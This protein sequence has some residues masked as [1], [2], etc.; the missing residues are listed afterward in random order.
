MP[1]AQTSFP[2]LLYPEAHPVLLARQML[3]FAIALQYLPL[4]ELIPGITWGA[5]IIALGLLMR[6]TGVADS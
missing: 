1:E 2:T 4:N 3:L 5:V 6:F